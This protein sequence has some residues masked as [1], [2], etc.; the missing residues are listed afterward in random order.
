MR[1]HERPNMLGIVDVKRPETYNSN[2]YPKGFEKVTIPE[3]KSG[4]WE[5]NKVTVSEDVGLYNLRLMRDGHPQRI[6]PPGEYTR[7]VKGNT[8]IMSDTP[9]E[10]HEHF[11]AW[12][13]ARGRVLINGLGLGFFLAA[14]LRKP[15]VSQITV[16]EKSQDVINLVG[17]YFTNHKVEIVNADA[18]TWQPPAG[19]RYGFV[20]HD[21]WNEIFEDNKEEM[22]HLR[23]KYGRRCGGN[24]ACWSQEYL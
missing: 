9:A 16:I 2:P 6:V 18:F 17:S 19:A 4:E 8:L 1:Y 12:S 20:W 5:V 24:Q 7:L 14:L 22:A 21:I 11:S 15:E 10:A 3:G 23:K 13:R